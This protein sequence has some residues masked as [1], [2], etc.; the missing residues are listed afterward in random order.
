MSVDVKKGAVLLLLVMGLLGGSFW[1]GLRT[2][3]EVEKTELVVV[4][5]GEETVESGEE[6]D[7]LR[8]CHQFS[9]SEFNER[10]HSVL[11]LSSFPHTGVSVTKTLFE[12]A[13]GISTY[14]QYAANDERHIEAC[15][16]QSG[17][18]RLYCRAD[19][20]G[21]QCVH[22]HP[23]PYEVPYLVNSH[24]PIYSQVCGSFGYDL[25]AHSQAI[26]MVRN[27]VDSFFTWF[28][29]HKKSH[30]DELDGVAL[31]DEFSEQYVQWHDYWRSHREPKQAPPSRMWIRF[32]DMCLCFPLFMNRVIEFTGAMPHADER[33]LEDAL[34]RNACNEAVVLGKDL[35]RCAS[36]HPRH[37][38]NALTVL[39]FVFSG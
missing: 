6:M 9:L 30:P 31:V 23:P 24:F 17:P 8:R 5:E 32:E 11:L 14:T 1:M 2:G 12:E 15:D 21:E 33:L 35:S 38:C 39:L 3:P 16:F 27:P 4:V 28:L 10:Q 25:P 13:T 26:H 7:M 36:T 37:S 20:E 34:R 22:S 19:G 29:D 18:W